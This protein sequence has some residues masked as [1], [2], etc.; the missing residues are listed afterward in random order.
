MKKLLGSLF[1]ALVL[2]GCAGV[3]FEPVHLSSVQGLNTQEVLQDFKA[4]LADHFSVLES[5]VLHYRGREMTLLGYSEVDEK[6]D[7]FAVAG[8]TPVGVKLFEVKMAKG[9]L[10]YSFAF[11]Q[12]KKNADPQKIA[13]ALA[14]D[15]RRIYLGRIPAAGTQVVRLKDRICYRQASGKGT[16][17]FIFGGPGT[18]LIEKRYWEGRHKIWRVRYFEYKASGAKIYPSKIF[19][20]HQDWKYKVTLRLKEILA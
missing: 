4:K 17:E 18:Y 10:K 12:M 2:S 3:P 16:L 9:D 5:A 6:A 14:A 13:E 7:A 20:E 15:I 19:F 1:L 8:V 11:P